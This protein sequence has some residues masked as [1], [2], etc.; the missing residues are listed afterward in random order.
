MNALPDP[1]HYSNIL[2]IN[3]SNVNCWSENNEE[4][5]AKLVTHNNPDIVCITETHLKD[6]QVLEVNG[7]DYYGLNRKLQVKNSRGSGGVRILVKTSLHAEFAVDRCYELKDNVLGLMLNSDVGDERYVVFCV[8]LPPE[9]SRY[10]Q[11]N[12]NILNKL[13]IELY[14]WCE[15]DGIFMCGDFNTRVGNLKDNIISDELSKCVVIDEGLNQQG[16]RLISFINDVR[17]CIVNGRVNPECDYYTSMTGYR[18]KAV[19]DYHITRESDINCIKRMSVQSCVD[20]VSTNQWEHLLTEKCHLPDHNLLVM[21][22]ECSKAVIEQ[23]VNRNLGS[24]I[25]QR[26]KIRRKVGKSYMNTETALR[27]IGDLLEEM[28]DVSETQH[29]INMK[30]ANLVELITNEAECSV[31]ELNK[32]RLG[33]KFKEYWDNELTVA[34]RNMHESEWIYRKCVKRNSSKLHKQGKWEH[35][36]KKQHL[37]DKLLKRKK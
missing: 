34:W 37:F 35:F 5:R 7:Y 19:V 32:K 21:D 23:L 10:G 6:D 14:R 29:D 18:G 24:V 31:N 11:E 30:Y 4:L 15:T 22:V 16:K 17:G 33:T 20:L 2:R 13:T 25:V 27:L 36:K 1:E 26:K 28:D 9:G 3:T 12:D 8:Y